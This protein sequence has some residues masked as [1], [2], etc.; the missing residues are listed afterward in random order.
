MHYSINSRLPI[1]GQCVLLAHY[2]IRRLKL[3]CFLVV[4]SRSNVVMRISLECENLRAFKK[5]GLW[6]YANKPTIK[7]R[8][9][10][11]VQLQCYLPL[12]VPLCFSTLQ[13]VNNTAGLDNKA[14]LESEK[15]KWWYICNVNCKNMDHIASPL[16]IC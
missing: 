1:R 16:F 14:Y 12:D 6:F 5:K 11:V 8:K 3:H 15:A 13:L 4:L 10:K 7:E 2:I 9:G